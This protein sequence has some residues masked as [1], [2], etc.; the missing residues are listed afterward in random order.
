MPR[1]LKYIDTNTAFEQVI[2]WCRHV[3]IAKMGDYGPS[4]RILRPSS[5]T[6]QIFIKANRLRSLQLKNTQLI[7]EPQEDA[8][9]A[10]VNYSAMAIIQLRMGI[11]DAPDLNASEAI[12]AYNEIMDEA[13]KLM[14]NKNHDYDE[15]WRSMRVSSITDI[16]L[17]KLHRIKQIEDNQ[18]KTAVSEGID[19]NYFDIINYAVFALI[20]LGQANHVPNQ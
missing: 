8:F 14:T 1:N 2:D 9:V 5:L 12:S 6:D 20:H 18:G 16:I 10:I 11:A 15:A 7:D 3:F 19:S 13:L 17:M 4:W